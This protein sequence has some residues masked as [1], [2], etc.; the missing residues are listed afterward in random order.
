[1]EADPGKG[2]FNQQNTLT[3]SVSTDLETP[4]KN[5]L[6]PAMPQ[7]SGKAADGFSKS[8]PHILLPTNVKGAYY[9]PAPPAEFDPNTATAAEL[10]RNGM[11]WRRPKPGDDPIQ[12]AAWNKVFS[13]KWDPARRI[14]PILEPQPGKTHLRTTR[15]GEGQ[16]STENAVSVW[17]GVTVFGTWTSVT[18][19]WR[20]P[21]VARPSESAGADGGWDSSSWVGIDG[22]GSNDVLQAG[23][24]Q[25]VG[26][27]GQPSYIAWFEWLAPSFKVTLN[28]TS[29]LCP[30]IASVGAYTFMAWK[31]DGNDNINI[32]ASLPQT[33]APRNFT[34]KV[35]FP[36]ATSQAPVL[37]I[38]NGHPFIAWIGSGNDNINIAEVDFDFGTNSFNGLN[39]TTLPDQSPCAPAIASLN[40]RLYVAWKGDGNDNINVMYS[41]DNGR[42]F[43]DKLTSPE[44]TPVAPCLVSHNGKLIIS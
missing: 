30:S 11:F 26:G 42:T 24:Q 44:T 3:M 12:L 21:S 10:I 14:V 35:T 27:N 8:M 7:T 38:H 6:I 37:C 43:I 23:I 17:S 25:S 29:P 33:S 40:G 5:L 1:M 28:E 31:G 9:T 4:E 19:T 41:T 13:I 15:T 18:G 20:V 34:V 16:N 36:E 2:N 39:K 22:N 32:I